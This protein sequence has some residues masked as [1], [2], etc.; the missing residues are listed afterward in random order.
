M[1]DAAF[2]RGI[3]RRLGVGFTHSPGIDVSSITNV[4]YRNFWYR[5]SALRLTP[6]ATITYRN[7]QV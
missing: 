5:R 6:Y 1:R 7:L 4:V 2:Y 3:V